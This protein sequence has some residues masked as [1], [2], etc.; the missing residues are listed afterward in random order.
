MQ[1]FKNRRATCSVEELDL[2]DLST[3]F[4]E[5]FG[6]FSGN[7]DYNMKTCFQDTIDTL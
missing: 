3:R 6:F 4:S 7:R 2:Q 5:I 1:T